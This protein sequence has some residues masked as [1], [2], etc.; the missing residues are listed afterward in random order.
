MA[1]PLSHRISA[2]WVINT[3]KY[4][5]SSNSP[6][7]FTRINRALRTYAV[8][9]ADFDGTL[10]VMAVRKNFCRIAHYSGP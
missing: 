8:M 6:S 9:S 1:A 10:L 3:H 7:S 5:T 2:F 4:G